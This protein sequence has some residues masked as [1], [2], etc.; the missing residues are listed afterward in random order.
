MFGLTRRE[1]R[2]KADQQAAE[3]LFSMATT[4]VSA[5]AEIRVAEAKTDV[6]ELDRLRAENSELRRLIERYRNETP[7]GHQPHMIAHEADAALG[8]V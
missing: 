5:A 1:Q 3:L 2:W 8:K 4:V 7:L 6:S